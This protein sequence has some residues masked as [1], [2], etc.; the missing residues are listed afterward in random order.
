MTQS[1]FLQTRGIARKAPFGNGIY[2]PITSPI[3][4][5]LPL[6]V[7]P[8]SAGFP[9]PADDYLEGNLNLHTYL[10]KRPAATFFAT[11]RG[12]SMVGAGIHS[13]NLLVV[14]RSLEPENRIVIALLEG[15]FIVRRLQAA[16][17]VTYLVA[18]NEAYEPIKISD[19]MELEIWGV[20]IA[21]IHF[22]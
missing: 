16:S 6:F 10:V 12:D 8:V 20:L 17:G 22:L 19:G 14:D 15:E 21:A 9:S 5:G 18:S 13:G 3:K 11:A 1:H 7:V 4:C 2:L